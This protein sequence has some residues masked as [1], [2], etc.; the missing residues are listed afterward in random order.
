[1][2]VPA[3]GRC[4]CGGWPRGGVPPPGLP[5]VRRAAGVLVWL[6][7]ACPG[8]GPLPEDLRAPGCGAGA[9]GVSHA[10]LPAFVLAWR[11]DVAETVGAVIAAGGRRRVRGAP[12]GGAGWGFRIR[13]RAGG[14]GGSRAA[15]PE[16][17]V[18]FAALAVELGG[19]AIRP[20]AE[21]GRFALA[22]IGAA[23]GAAAG[24]PGWLAA[25]RVAVRVGGERRE[26]DRG[27]H[28]LALPDRRQT[29]FHASCPAMTG[30]KEEPAWTTRGR[31]QIALHRWAVIAEAAG[32][33]LTA[34]GAG[35]AGPADRRTRPHAPGRVG[36]PLLAGD[37]RPV[38]AGVAPGGL[39][40][41]KP[42]PRA[43]TGVGPRAPGAVRRGR[44]AAAGAARPVGRA[45]RLDPVSPARD[46]GRRADRPRP[47]APG[48]AAPRGAGRRAEGLRPV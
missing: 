5:V 36:P 44:R 23:F 22:A 24:L 13:R 14:C 33:K 29:A 40:A 17:G 46:H 34:A 21:P 3:A 11:L 8:G 39:D 30:M 32:Q 37:D 31:K 20:A 41:L 7:A 16:L 15:A 28:N 19:E 2:A 35:R 42:S 38:A 9:C 26:A 47:A 48:R 43:D 45:D 27:Q 10:L 4:L 1:M 18:A 6:L 25:G 12:G